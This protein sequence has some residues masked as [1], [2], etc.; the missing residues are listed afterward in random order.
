MG[1][2]HPWAEKLLFAVQRLITQN[3]GDCECLSLNRT[4]LSSSQSLGDHCGRRDRKNVRK[5]KDDKE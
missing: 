1:F 3:T 2:S 5:P 4:S